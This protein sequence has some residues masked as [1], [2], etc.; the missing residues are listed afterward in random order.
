MKL[1]YGIFAICWCCFL[2]DVEDA[3]VLGNLCCCFFLDGLRVDA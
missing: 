3:Y 1:L 2:S